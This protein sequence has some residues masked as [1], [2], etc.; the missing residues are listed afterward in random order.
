MDVLQ[1]PETIVYFSQ[2]SLLEIQI[3]VSLGKLK[4]D[5]PPETVPA[6]SEDSG[7]VFLP[8]SQNFQQAGPYSPPLNPIIS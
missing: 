8:L 6:L 4:L 5:F 7:L 1:R 3:K 2:V